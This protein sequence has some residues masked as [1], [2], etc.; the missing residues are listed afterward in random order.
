MYDLRLY[1]TEM[2]TSCISL[3][4]IFDHCELKKGDL[5]RECPREIRVN[6]ALKL[7][8]WRVFGNILLIPKE[9]LASIDQENQ[10]EDQ[11]K[12]I[13]LESWH[14]KESKRATC[15]MLANKLNIHNRGD[16]VAHLCELIKSHRK[17]EPELGFV[18][19]REFE[20]EETLDIKL[21]SPAG[22][23]FI[24]KKKKKFMSRNIREGCSI[25]YFMI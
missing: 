25:G 13:L 18:Q 5:E 11:K 15:L 17:T 6:I 1:L 9:K 3:T 2:A 8:D 19:S 24:C 7:T 21:D 16:L 10:S 14:E 12:I 20:L 22:K 23:A 4:D